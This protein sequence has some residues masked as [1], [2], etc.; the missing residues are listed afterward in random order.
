MTLKPLS[1]SRLTRPALLCLSAC[2]LAV[3]SAQANL[4]DDI[5]AGTGYAALDLCTRTM[6]SGD[7]YLKVRW[8][9]VVPKV[10]PLPAVWLVNYKAGV[11]VDVQSYVPFITHKRTAIFRQGLGCTIVPPG[12]S[13]S[14]VRAQA[15]RA[16]ATPASSTQ[17]WPL[18]DGPVESHLSSPEQAR[19]L[20]SHGDAIFAETTTQANQKQNTIA[21]LVARDGHLIYERYAKGYQRQQAQLGWSMTKSL[22]AMLAGAM[23]TDQRLSLDAPVGLPQW[24]GS[25]KAAITWRQLLNM[26]PGLAWDEGYE[27]ASDATEMLFSQG[28][29]GQWAADRPLT[30]TPGTVFTYSTGFANVAMWRMRQILGGSHQALY[31]YYQQRLFAP[32]G[33]TG[34]VIEPDASGTPVGGARGVLRPVDW[35]RLGQLVA[36]GGVWRGQTLIDPPT[37]DFLLAP[38][39][40]SAEYGGMIWRQPAQAIPAELRARLPGDLV[41]FAGHMGQYVVIV[42]S[43][44]V[45]VARMGASFDKPETIRR[46]FSAVADLLDQP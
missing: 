34:G 29:E 26:A 14:S 44:Q 8:N 37:M 43:R 12:I 45:V 31:D 13:E 5:P 38:S 10:Q 46:V 15:F 35:L 18:G 33:I 11:K 17:A 24:S 20:A 25:P 39:P 7:D 23:A 22:T 30:S 41:W 1:R 27:G 32:L 21:F 28:N 2:V 42:P 16:V 40:A 9:Y 36:Q 4:I 19:L 3:G 6:Q